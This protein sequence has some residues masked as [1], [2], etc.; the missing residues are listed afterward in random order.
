LVQSE[1]VDPPLTSLAPDIG[2]LADT[3]VALLVE[4]IEQNRSNTSNYE[5]V[6]TP[7]D[8]RIRESSMR[9]SHSG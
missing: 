5:R 4:Q 3:A 8:L 2:A 7:F 1:Y 6:L 9:T